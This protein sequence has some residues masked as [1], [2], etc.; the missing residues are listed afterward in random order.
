MPN[1]NDLQVNVV[2]DTSGIEASIKKLETVM[3]K[4]STTVTGMGTKISEA[5]NGI[6][7]AITRLGKTSASSS[8]KVTGDLKAIEAQAKKT[9]VALDA[10]GKLPQADAGGRLRTPTGQFANAATT[11]AKA[12]SLSLLSNDITMGQ[13]TAALKARSAA[14][15]ELEA[16][17]KA[18]TKA[19]AEADRVAKSKLATDTSARYAL[20]DLASAYG[21]VGAAILAA[22][23]S[24]VKI[25]ADAESSF[26]NVERTMGSGATVKSVNNIR[27][28]LLDLSTQIPK[29]FAEVTTIATLGNQLGIAEEDLVS[30]TKTVS[31]F[32]ATTGISIDGVAQ[33][34]GLLGNLLQ[35]PTDRFNNLASAIALV[36][37]NAVATEPQIIAVA[38]QIAAG[39]NGAGFAADQV[40]GL[41]GALASLKVSPEQSRSSLTTYF[42]ALNQAVANGGPELEKFAH[43]TGLTA[44]QLDGLVRSGT[45]G[46]EIFTKFLKGLNSTDSIGVTTA[47]DELGL[48]GLRV[49]NTFRRLSQNPGLVASTFADAEEGMTSG[50]EATRQY[51]LIADDF[52]QVMI[53]LQSAVAAV[54]AEMGSG[55]LPILSTLG[56]EL[57]TVINNV[58]DFMSQPWAKFLAGTITFLGFATS[59]LIS[60]R[61][62]TMLATA[63][64]IAF[65]RAQVVLNGSSALTGVSGLMR[66]IVP[67]I[68]GFSTATKAATVATTG[69]TVASTASAAA[70]TSVG[71]ATGFAARAGGL[72]LSIFTKIIP[73]LGWAALGYTAVNLFATEMNR[74][75]VE[76]GLAEAGLAAVQ[77]RSNGGGTA[78]KQMTIDIGDTIGSLKTLSENKKQLIADD[79]ALYES[80]LVAGSGIE[81]TAQAANTFD[82]AILKNKN[83]VNAVNTQIGVLDTQMAGMVNEGNFTEMTAQLEAQ[84]ITAVVAAKRLPLYTMALVRAQV[85]AASLIP[86]KFT[87]DLAAADDA[88]ASAEATVASFAD[89]AGGSGGG[90]GGA[91]QKVRTLSDYASD[92]AGVFKRSFNIR[93]SSQSALDEITTSFM[94]LQEQSQK[95]KD[96]LLGL[97][98]D[99]SVKEYFLSVADAFGDTLRSGQLTSEISDI[100]NDI[101]DAQSNA[102]TELVGNS[103][104]AIRNRAT[105]TGMVSSY[106]DYI[107][108]LADSGAT[109]EELQAAIRRGRQDF[110]AQA[111]QLGFNSNQLGAYTSHFDDLSTTVLNVPRNVTVSANLNPAMQAINEFA[112]NAKAA[113]A[114]AGA[115]S[116]SAYGSAFANAQ[117]AATRTA[118]N[119][120]IREQ[121]ALINKYKPFTQAEAGRVANLRS[122]LIPGYATG[123]YTGSGGKYD[124]AGVV[125][126]GEY[127]V[128]K[129]Q[130]NQSTGMPY[131]GALSQMK[132]P[133]YFS[134][135]PVGGNSGMMVVSL[136]P[137]D[138]GL[139]R[140]VGGSGQVVLYA[141]SKELARSVN[142][143][144][145]QIVAQ[146]GRQ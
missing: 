64:T 30:F 106:D 65:A 38:E 57:I 24:T 28:S 67:Q 132:N 98:A 101:A 55:M 50:T 66:T 135:G 126:R 74:L 56:T 79:T 88:V 3:T 43:I 114:Q 23:V 31:E 104:A 7:S 27:E 99:K 68:L 116:G 35:V 113:S 9:K 105:M 76:A 11:G 40:I 41:A 19:T 81:R 63:T 111:T 108:S 10:N 45:G 18:S 53:M 107:Q 69:L 42:N 62:V 22:S 146:G 100:N 15:A 59:A 4:F 36:G 2:G 1:P 51:A 95:A 39:A 92:L 33:A 49:D 75:S 80:S 71:V 44:K 6:D 25:A 29:T 72:L 78:M 142:N 123:G 14:N 131:E 48:S 21:V 61:I 20:Y 16:K 17:T 115:A 60:Y 52:N 12:T 86:A 82:A 144:N 118:R 119:N 129:S 133:S 46:E 136:S 127:V 13:T 47:L 120:E 8:G 26:T 110:V 77:E 32:S 91:A 70:T 5:M 117:L 139:L 93:F 58:R 54:V 102:S 85:A 122:L 140:Q 138:R 121:I 112:A 143:G 103:R 124:V 128:P 141:D 96:T 137:E 125:H 37:L 145:R 89:A 97:S 134:G 34:F 84:G 83:S 94:D 130:V 73:V 90:G 109:Q 87:S